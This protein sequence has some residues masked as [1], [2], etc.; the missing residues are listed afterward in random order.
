MDYL[1]QD[2]FLFYLNKNKQKIIFLLRLSKGNLSKKFFI[3]F[4]H[5]SGLKKIG[6]KP[7]K[8]RLRSKS[9]QTEPRSRSTPNQ[10]E[11][12]IPCKPEQAQIM[13]Q[14]QAEWKL[15]PGYDTIVGYIIHVGLT[16]L[17]YIS[18]VIWFN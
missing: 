6:S 17:Y 16:V 12:P 11:I 8:T 10:A 9:I 7:N 13:D 15:E 4:P 14:V 18:N 3:L 2:P 5:D 1:V